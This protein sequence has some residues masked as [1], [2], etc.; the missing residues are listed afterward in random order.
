[1]RLKKLKIAGFKSFG[2][3]TSMNFD[4]SVVGVVGPNGCGKSNIVDAFRWVLG[5]QS[6]RLRGDKME[7]V[8]FAGTK[9]RPAQNMA[10]VSVTFTGVQES[11]HLPFDELTIT[12]RCTRDGES[13]YFI[14]GKNARLK[15]VQLL[16]SGSG[17]GKHGV[18][19][20]EQGKLDQ[21]IYL[22]P[23]ERRKLFDEAAGIGR[24]LLRKQESLHKLHEVGQNCL[25]IQDLHTEVGKKVEQL[26]KQAAL[27]EKHLKWQAECLSLQKA[28][29]FLHYSQLD[30]QLQACLIQIEVISK[31]SQE[32]E[33]EQH[34]LKKHAIAFQEMLEKEEQ[35]IHAL[36]KKIWQIHGELKVDEVRIQEQN[37]RKEKLTIEIAA[38]EKK[39]LSLEKECQL[40]YQQ[41]TRT[42]K[43]SEECQEQQNQLLIALDEAKRNN[44]EL[45]KQGIALITG[46]DKKQKE[47][48][49]FLERSQ[50]IAL[51][52]N[53]YKNQERVCE[54]EGITCTKIIEEETQKEHLLAAI[55]EEKNVLVKKMTAEIEASKKTLEQNRIFLRNLEKNKEDAEQSYQQIAQKVHELHAK[56]KAWQALEE[57][58]AGFSEGAQVL[59]RMS[60]NKKS[61]LY[62][63]IKSLGDFLIPQEGAE[64][65]VTA[66]LSFYLDTLIVQ[67]QEDWEMVIKY[68]K[69][70]K[71]RHFSLFC[72]DHITRCKALKG[73][74]SEYMHPNEL[75]VHLLGK[76][77][78]H[79]TLQADKSRQ[80]V[81]E[82]GYFIDENGVL[83]S[84]KPEGTPLLRKKELQKIEKSLALIL[85]THEQEKKKLEQLRNEEKILVQETNEK[86]IALRKLEMVH[87]TEKLLLQTKVKEWQS[88][89]EKRISFLEKERNLN[90]EKKALFIKIKELEEE[91]ESRKKEEEAF[92][93]IFNELE[94]ALDK[95]NEAI[96]QSRVQVLE[97]QKLY[98][99]AFE[100]EKNS[101]SELIILKKDILAKEEEL[102]KLKIQ[103]IHDEEE[104][105]R[106]LIDQK[107]LQDQ[108]QEKK[109]ELIKEQKTLEDNEIKT[110]K[111]KNE[112][113]LW[114]GDCQKKENALILLKEK[115][116]KLEISVAQLL[117][118]KKRLEE[119]G[120]EEVPLPSMTIK[121]M[122]ERIEEI[123]QKI[124]KKEAV[125]F[126]SIEDLKREKEQF[127]V[128]DESLQDVLKAKKDLEL[129]IQLL[130]RESK[131]AFKTTFQKIRERFK[132]HFALLFEGG[133]ADL[134]L[135]SESDF[136]EAGVEIHAK[137]PGK[138]MQRLSLLS[139]G[140]KCLTALAL[141]F[142]FFAVAPAPFCILD[143]V[144]APLD[145]V[146]V[147]RFTNLLK[148][149]TEKTQF[150]VVT[151][152]KKTMAAADILIGV[153]ME[154]KGVSRLLSL[155]FN[156]H[157]IV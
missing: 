66:A 147:E 27:A 118:Q 134:L 149:F 45:E 55:I 52:Y 119:E 22:Q 42:K 41:M 108:M 32:K 9:T 140:E 143:E 83:F 48:Y 154:E 8:L 153:S 141:L 30:N 39:I 68:A 128:L 120:I 105:E 54:K 109:E 49:S 94:L 20:F 107:L 99:H 5:E 61:P 90:E 114:Q 38:R 7:D 85:V 111:S 145:E 60:E 102:G 146:N 80:Y 78:V 81:T 18:A 19:I 155:L 144:D 93:Q 124:T 101:K 97:R 33:E 152:N 125:N 67:T 24:F 31:E 87:L 129:A 77:R 59:L 34:H 106:F 98:Q 40:L 23:Q 104:N 157:A 133:E 44:E 13:D 110:Q 25:R 112:H 57:S 79:S 3:T 58:Q 156:A 131:K 92:S 151:H 10:E 53:E 76:I 86:E 29:R 4:G 1:M 12:R 26:Q 46:R 142:A 148:Q 72:L 88:A 62:S 132:E 130:D 96:N 135:H 116:H 89:S 17:L 115:K 47:R 150:L 11:L 126:A 127:S 65:V 35:A 70:K 6:G 16:F 2:L 74:V 50:S 73:S 43:Q 137:P 36:Q 15:D 69:E 103:A 84:H 123:T 117:A 95:H 138:R 28:H 113:L 136:F 51:Q 37:K 100:K 71:I 139:G 64:I 63:K 91:R 75:G 14:N 121:E 21:I 122:Q 82:E 56:Q